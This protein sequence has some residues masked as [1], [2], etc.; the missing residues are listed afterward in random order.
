MSRYI[1]ATFVGLLFLV[2]NADAGHG[3]VCAP[4][5]CGLSEYYYWN[6]RLI[7][8]DNAICDDAVEITV[9]SGQKMWGIQCNGNDDAGSFYGSLLMPENW[10]PT[11]TVKFRAHYVSVNATPSDVI[12]VDIK[13]SCH[14]DNSTMSSTYGT[15]A[16]MS[17]TYTTQ[18]RHEIAGPTVVTPLINNCNPATPNPP[19]MLIW[20]AEVDATAS[21]DGHV[22]DN[23]LLGV[24][25]EYTVSAN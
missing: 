8:T 11:Q 1:L 7:S 12:D 4:N 17:T 24:T 16:R 14:A 15:E 10:V 22:A 3:P 13:A 19:L 2:G 5:Q 20:K 18:N 9:A 23:Y 6:A 25:M 21:G